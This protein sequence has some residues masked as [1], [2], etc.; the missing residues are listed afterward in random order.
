MHLKRWLSAHRTALW[1]H[2]L[3]TDK[4]RDAQY[5]DFCRSSDLWIIRVCSFG[6]LLW[7]MSAALTVALTTAL[8]GKTGHEYVM[9]MV[10]I[11]F[12]LLPSSVMCL[13]RLERVEEWVRRHAKLYYYGSWFIFLTVACSQL[14]VMPRLASGCVVHTW[15]FVTCFTVQMLYPGFTAWLRL[16]WLVLSL[17]IATADSMIS[18]TPLPPPTVPL[19]FII[20]VCFC[21]Q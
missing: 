7:R 6:L 9:H 8:T 5:F 12:L 16:L 15:D 14:Y 19:L 3:V 13:I 11:S 18:G 1:T 17:G 4:D 20:L 2:S 21:F 10:I